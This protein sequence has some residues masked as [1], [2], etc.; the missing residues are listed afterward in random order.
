MSSRKNKSISFEYK[1]RAI[2]L[3]KEVGVLEAARSLGIDHQRIS[4]WKKQ[5]V[6]IQSVPNKKRAR[7]TG[8]GKK[9]IAPDIEEELHA[10][11]M[12]VTFQIQIIKFPG[13]DFS[14]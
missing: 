12:M 14:F 10:W 1:S 3:A 5:E 9:P 4:Q 13:K 8:G 6:I 11:I 2:S 7:L